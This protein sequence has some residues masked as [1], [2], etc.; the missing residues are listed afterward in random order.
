MWSTLIR[1]QEIFICPFVLLLLGFPNF[2]I[3]LFRNLFT[4][5]FINFNE[6]ENHFWIP[7]ETRYQSMEIKKKKLQRLK[8]NKK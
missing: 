6:G 2:S 1:I 8:M 7:I 3:L 5:V 4:F